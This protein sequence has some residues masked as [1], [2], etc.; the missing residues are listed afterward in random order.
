[1]AVVSMKLVAAAIVDLPTAVLAIIS[2]FLVFKY[3]INSAWLVL[4][5][6]LIGF[7]I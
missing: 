7:F 5:G 6:G 3:N 1:M 4:G 2:I